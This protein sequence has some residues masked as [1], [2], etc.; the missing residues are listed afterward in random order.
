M[1]ISLG[2][3]I[4]KGPW[5][6]GNNFAINLSKYLRKRGCKV[7]FD[8]KAKNLD[9][10]ILMDPRKKSQS[11]SF[12]D[13]DIINYQKNNKKT[14]VIHRINECDER[15]NTNYVN[16][17]LLN[18]NRVADHTVFISNWLKKTLINF[19]FKNK[20]NSTIL[21]GADRGLFKYSNNNWKSGK[22]K[23]VTHHWSNHPNKGSKVYEL[24][25]KLLEK[26]EWKKIIE[27]YYVG[28]VPKNI[29]F[30]NTIVYKPM[31]G[32]KLVNFLSSCHIYITGSINEPGGNHQNEAANLGLPVLYLK[33][34]C[35]EEYCRGYGIAFNYNNLESKLKEIIKK[36]SYFKKKLKHYP[37]H[38]NKTCEAYFN[39]FINLQ[40]KRE[41]ILAKKKIPN[42]Y[43]IEKLKI[44]LQ[45]II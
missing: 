29:N 19:G 42:L 39:L 6:G 22:I 20:N 11:S 10:I 15:K 8:L 13:L 43:F 23:I 4:K 26:H 44:Y 16:K 34:G 27:F 35:M 24:I 32:K 5:G 9:F 18:A 17:E 12:N 31:H 7:Y 33:S 37:Y 38:S 3:K 21:N 45:K 1:K 30:K 40:K 2:V 28:N 25:N 14:I 41:K 36:Y